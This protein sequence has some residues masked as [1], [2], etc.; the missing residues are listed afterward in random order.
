MI[1][2]IGPEALVT[3]IAPASR[4]A[5]AGPSDTIGSDA[6]RFVSGCARQP[7]DQRFAVRSF[8]AL[9]RRAAGDAPH[10]AVSDSVYP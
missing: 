1:F 2:T 3:S 4:S 7:Q 8:L 6:Q 10:P 5:V 9:G